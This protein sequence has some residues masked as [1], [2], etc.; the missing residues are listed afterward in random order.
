MTYL[1]QYCSKTKGRYFIWSRRRRICGTCIKD[2]NGL[3]EWAVWTQACAD[4]A[5]DSSIRPRFY[6]LTDVWGEDQYFSWW[7]ILPSVNPRSKSRTLNFIFNDYISTN[8]LLAETLP[9][10]WNTFDLYCK[11]SVIRLLEEFEEHRK[12]DSQ[13]QRAWALKK[14][15]ERERRIT[16]SCLSTSSTSIYSP[17]TIAR[18]PMWGVAEKR[19]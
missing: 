11:A 2:L 4:I 17:S 9:L 6:S 12:L 13:A 3:L 1:S 19:K 16:V 18:P 5:N 15:D 10:D 8:T 7:T 14:L